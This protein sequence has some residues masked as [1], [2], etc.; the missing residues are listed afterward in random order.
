MPQ[1]PMLPP[2]VMA[3]QGAATGGV[4]PAQFLIAAADLHAQGA[5]PSQ[6]DS[7]VG[8]K[9]GKKNPRANKHIQVVK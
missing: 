9:L 1:A 6:N 2:D 4:S 8:P 5:L 7:S 3:Q